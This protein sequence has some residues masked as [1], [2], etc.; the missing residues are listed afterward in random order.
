MV[1]VQNNIK[2]LP[3][4]ALKLEAKKHPDYTFKQLLL[5]VPTHY[6]N[7][8]S[9]EQAIKRYAKTGII[10]KFWQDKPKGAT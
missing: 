6:S 5:A 7:I 8:T 2:D 3:I 9:A 1:M 4:D 10:V